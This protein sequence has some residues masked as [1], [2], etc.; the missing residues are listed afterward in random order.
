M[1]LI[2]IYFMKLNQ[3]CDEIKSLLLNIIKNEFHHP[4]MHHNKQTYS[5][6]YKLYIK[7]LY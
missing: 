1:T 2:L 6:I 3:F 5:E 4:I 7:L